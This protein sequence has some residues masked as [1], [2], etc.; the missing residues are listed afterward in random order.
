MPPVPS[1]LAARNVCT[2]RRDNGVGFLSLLALP[3]EPGDTGRVADAVPAVVVHLTTNEQVAGEDLLL[4]GLL[5]TVL[6][7]VDLFHGDDDL[8]DLLLHVH[9]LDTSG[10]VGGDLLLVA[11]LGV[12]HVP[13][14]RSGPGVVDDLFLFGLEVFGRLG[15]GGQV[16]RRVHLVVGE[17]GRRGDVVRLDEFG[18]SMGSTDDLSVS[19]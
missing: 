5:A 11:R 17:F 18:V 14:T 3:H 4:H 16:E 6:E 19:G 8:V 10:E 13:L 12:D 2:S 9:A 15:I 7:L 1:P